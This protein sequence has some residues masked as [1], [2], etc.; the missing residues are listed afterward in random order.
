[1]DADK[2]EFF[3]QRTP[4]GA[5]ALHTAVLYNSHEVMMKLIEYYPD[6]VNLVHD[7]GSDVYKGMANTHYCTKL[8]G[9]LIR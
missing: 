7:G 3:G 2:A 4:S 9:M 5:T 6:I 1:M 8:N